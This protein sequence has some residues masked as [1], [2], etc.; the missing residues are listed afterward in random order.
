VRVYIIWKRSM[1]NDSYKKYTIQAKRGI[2]GEAFFEAL[3][4]DYCLPHRIAS[5]KD[6]GIDYICEWVY[7][8]R[9]TGILYAVQVKTFSEQTSKPQFIEVDKRLNGL[10]KF[11]IV[12][13]NLTIDERTLHYW[14]GLGMPVYLFAVVQ[15][16]TS[17]RKEEVLDCYY[18]RFTEVLTTRAKQEDF[19][20]YKV[21]NR[22]AFIAFA[23][24]EERRLGFA[25]DLFIDLMRC[26][27]SKGSIS[28]I[29][30]RTLG[31][32]QFPEEG[33]VFGDLFEEYHENILRTYAKTRKFLERIWSNRAE[34]TAEPD[35]ES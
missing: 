7:G 34:P 24:P 2:K 6:V 25:R 9:P 30:P 22:S 14:K 23:Q 27:Y 8:D 3:I 20:F 18:K 28:Y 1:D 12:N 17:T 4:S 26:S 35:E 33:A 21:N 15:S 16:V 5:P 29:S 31:L 13:Q 10:W 32:E 11:R 19:D